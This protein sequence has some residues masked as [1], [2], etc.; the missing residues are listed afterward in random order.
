MKTLK[1][2]GLFLAALVAVP[3]VVALFI[4]TKIKVEREIQINKPVQEVFQYIVLLRNQEN[5]SKWATM[6][7][8]TKHTFRGTDGQVGFVSAWDS[9]K[10]DVG[11]GEQEI[12]SITPNVKIDYELRFTRPF[13]SVS[14]TS[15][16]TEK[17]NENATNVKWAYEGSMP[18]PTNLTLL[19]MDFNNLL[20]NDFQ[21]GLKKLKSILEED[22]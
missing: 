12:L 14:K 11:A 19:F 5:Y 1:F 20:G 8:D 18:Y 3:L 17:I 2:I 10:D 21:Y 16:Y 22:V 15:F 7:P 13:S 4:S 6:D 9:K